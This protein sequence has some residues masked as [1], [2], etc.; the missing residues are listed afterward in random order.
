MNDILEMIYEGMYDPCTNKAIF[1][2]GGPGSGKTWAIKR[3]G[4]QNMGFVLIDSDYAL[5]RYMKK[6]GLS[7]KMPE[8]EHDARTN[9]R[10]KA[11]N[12]THSKRKTVTTERLGL[13]ISET[14]SKIEDILKHKKQLERLDY[15]TAIIFI[16]ADLETAHFR[17]QKRER[18]VP[19]QIVDEKWKNT[20]KNLGK[21]QQQFNNFFIVDNSEGS[22]TG[23]QILNVFKKIRKWCRL[24]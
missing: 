14:G 23:L 13:V 6:A 4:L 19:P 10:Q 11:K 17:N 15:D 1:V 9:V 24:K 21:F 5:E 7:L 2:V 12:V 22:N 16:N 3:L 20:Q 18:S 8:H